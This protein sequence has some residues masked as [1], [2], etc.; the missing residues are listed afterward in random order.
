MIPKTTDGR[1]LFMIPWHHRIVI[2]TT[3]TLIE[4]HSLEP[5]PW[6]EEIDFILETTN[7]YLHKNVSRADVLSVFVGLRPLA[8]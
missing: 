8:A 3:D 2:R 5:K 4:S 6:E 7:S 1:V